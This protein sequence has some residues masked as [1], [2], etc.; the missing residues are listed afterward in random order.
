MGR[1]KRQIEAFACSG[2]IKEHLLPV[3][4]LVMSEA[5][6]CWLAREISLGCAA[7]VSFS[8]DVANLEENVKFVLSDGYAFAS[9]YRPALL[10]AIAG[11]QVAM[12][13]ST[14]TD[15]GHRS[16]SSSSTTIEF[17]ISCQGASSH[18]PVEPC[19]QAAVE[20][21]SGD[22]RGSGHLAENVPMEVED[23]SEESASLVGAHTG[24]GTA[25]A[26][27]GRPPSAGPLD[28]QSSG[29]GPEARGNAKLW[30]MEDIQDWVR[31][32]VHLAN[33]PASDELDKGSCKQTCLNKRS[34]VIRHRWLSA[35]THIP[36]SLHGDLQQMLHEM[37]ACVALSLAGHECPHVG[38]LFFFAH[39]LRP[40][41]CMYGWESND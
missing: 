34:E 32:T 20:A 35:E 16:H 9:T 26:V 7:Q 29:G 6:L 30:S 27:E 1:H 39:R 25:S 5:R 3:I 24:I 8:H 31:D 21:R 13:S 14:V 18:A 40:P 28:P 38:F 15:E 41:V 22:C 4:V 10:S 37:P 12:Q 36:E 19:A 33:Q 2:A 23:G 11:V 17:W